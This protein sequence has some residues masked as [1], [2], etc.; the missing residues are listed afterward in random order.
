MLS[1]A[2]STRLLVSSGRSGCSVASNGHLHGSSRYVCTHRFHATHFT[3][4]DMDS[5]LAAQ[6]MH[7]FVRSRLWIHQHK[8]RQYHLS[9]YPSLNSQHVTKR[10]SIPLHRMG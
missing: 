5:S 4:T 9:T 8:L 2:L 1:T 6:R 3:D 10:S 7:S